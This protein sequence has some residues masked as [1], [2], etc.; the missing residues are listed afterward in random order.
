MSVGVVE[1]SQTKNSIQ[2]SNGF[3]ATSAPFTQRVAP[4][5]GLSE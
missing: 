1:V 3:P 4:V 2:S 5:P